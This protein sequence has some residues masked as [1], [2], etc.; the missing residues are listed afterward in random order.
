MSCY[1]EIIRSDNDELIECVYPI[2]SKDQN[3]RDYNQKGGYGILHLAA[4]GD[5]PKVLH[6]LL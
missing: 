5:G 4:M 2:V 1:E 6:F 3:N